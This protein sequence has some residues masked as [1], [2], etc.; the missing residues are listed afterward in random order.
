M[1]GLE[2]SKKYFYNYALDKFKLAPTIYPYLA[3]GLVGEGSE[4]YGLDDE[5]SQDHDFGV[6]FCVW[7]PAKYWEYSF[8]VE[9][10]LND[11]PREYFGFR[12]LEN[13]VNNR[14]GLWS[15]EGFYAKYTAQKQFPILLEDWLKIPEH[16]LSIATNG[17]VFLDNYGEFSKIRTYLLNYYPSDV[18]KK[19]LSAYLAIMAQSGQY[20]LERCLKRKDLFGFCLARAEFIDSL[21]GVLYLLC[22]KYR[23]YYKLTVSNL[24]SL[25][26]YPQAF[27]DDILFIQL[28]N[29]YEEVLA[30]V[31]FICCYVIKILKQRY[32][33]KTQSS[34]LMEI[35]MEIQ[36]LIDDSKLKKMHLMRGNKCEY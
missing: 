3:F 24:L 26:Y 18:L 6:D 27:L 7:L 13:T 32:L 10:I 28:S 22:G 23:P 5:L 35:A 20:N 29:D 36:G 8:E 25:N 12:L 2:L 33:I 14:R 16:F 30:K 15:I 17:E 4:C 9:K 31:E 1:Q 21:F 34:F 11:L 19:K